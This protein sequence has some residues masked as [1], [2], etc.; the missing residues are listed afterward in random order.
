MRVA[1]AT[2]EPPSKHASRG[3]S[4]ARGLG[5]GYE[6]DLPCEGDSARGPRVLKGHP[7]GRFHRAWSVSEDE[8]FTASLKHSL[9]P[10]TRVC[11]CTRQSILTAGNQWQRP[12][13][14][15]P[16]P[17]CALIG[18]TD[19]SREPAHEPLACSLRLYK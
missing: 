3:G 1:M 4:G 5:L 7:P 14:R 9:T 15:A 16:P 13:A 11:V 17:P 6:A 19:G 8:A 12:V 2:Q 18:R 10:E